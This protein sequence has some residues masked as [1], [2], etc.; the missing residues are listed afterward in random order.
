MASLSNARARFVRS[1][2]IFVACG[3][4]ALLSAGCS[5]AGDHHSSVAAPGQGGSGAPSSADGLGVGGGVQLNVNSG[6]AASAGVSEAC[7]TTRARAQAEPAVLEL[8]LDI[9]GSM[10]WPPGWAPPADDPQQ[11]P[12]AGTTKWDITGPALTAAVDSLSPDTAL[13][14]SLFPNADDCAIDQPELPIT[15]LGAAGSV[16]R[17]DFAT[18]IQNVSPYGGTPTEDAYA[19]GVKYLDR[20]KLPGQKFLLLITDGVPT[21]AANCKGDGQTPVP[22]QALIAVAAA[23]YQKGIRTFV[24]GSPGSEAART[25]LSAMA[26]AG[27][28]AQPGCLDQG[29]TYCHFDMTQQKDLS[30]GLATALHQIAS[31]IVSCQYAIP[32][33]PSGQ[34]LD[35]GKVNVTFTASDGSTHSVPRDASETECNSGWQYSPDGKTIQLCKDACDLVNA[36]HGSNKSTAVVFGC[37]NQDRGGAP[38]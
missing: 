31:S 18:S 10:A 7:V 26:S 22:T 13:G 16:A 15:I 24:I 29:P 5:A 38:K 3:G 1:T 19:L 27:H 9:S 36:D 2:A 34:T 6:G 20:S 30:A 23:A 11:G 8:V 14:L 32:D 17:Q 25:P 35:K 28:T 21:Y 4:A 33:A 37:V 12:P